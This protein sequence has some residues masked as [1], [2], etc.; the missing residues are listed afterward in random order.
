MSGECEPG[1]T[2]FA[3]TAAVSVIQAKPSRLPRAA[4][5]NYPTRVLICRDDR[6]LL[7]WFLRRVA[8]GRLGITP[9]EIDGGHTSA[10]S[11]PR[12]LADRREACAAE[13]GLLGDH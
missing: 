2:G 1:P 11:R 7:H 10:L 9:G 12:E 6:L 5:R 8:R 3:A 13:R 4:E